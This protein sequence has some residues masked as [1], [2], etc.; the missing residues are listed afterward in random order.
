M[1]GFTEILVIV[2]IVLLI[3]GGPRLMREVGQ[4]VSETRKAVKE[5]KIGSALKEAGNEIQQALGE[6]A[7]ADPLCVFVCSQQD[8]LVIERRTISARLHEL[9]SVG[10]TRPILFE[11]LPASPDTAEEVYTRAIQRAELVIVVIADDISAPVVREHRLARQMGKPC[12]YFVKSGG[13]RSPEAQRFLAEVS[14]K[15]VEYQMPEDLSDKVVAAVVADLL[16][17]WRRRRLS[18]LDLGALLALG[19]QF[20]LDPQILQRARQEEQ[21]ERR[22]WKSGKDEPEMVYVPAGYFWMGSD[23]QDEDAGS[24]EKPRQHYY[25]LGYWIGRYPVTNR[26]YAKFLQANSEHSAPSGWQERQFPAGN[27]DHPVM[28][29]TWTDALAYCRWLSGST[30]KNYTLPS[31]A[32]WEKA[33]RGPDGRI[34]PWGNQAPDERRCNFNAKVGTTTQVGS[35]SPLGDSPYGCADM[36][37]NVWEWTRSEYR[38]YPYRADDGREDLHKDVHRVVRGGSFHRDGRYTRC[39]CRFWWVDFFD[40]LVGF[41][42]AVRSHIS[43]DSGRSGL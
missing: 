18:A 26:Q 37:G 3:F 8:E 42:V 43:L 6:I 32:E 19:E 1:L 38:D 5:T 16:E 41:R 25:L 13:Q 30:R 29:V 27:D 33:G 31:E 34:Y 24:D 10:L 15:W 28:D 20:K 11:D 35:Y 23:E 22:A 9:G 4:A 21:E 12:L 39:A 2:V 40:D 14:A 36:A 7:P 17:N